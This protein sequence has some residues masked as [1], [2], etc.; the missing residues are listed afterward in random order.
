MRLYH[1]TLVRGC[2]YVEDTETAGAAPLPFLTP[3]PMGQLIP[4]K[5]YPTMLQ[6]KTYVYIISPL[7]PSLLR[8]RYR[9]FRWGLLKRCLYASRERT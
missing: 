2:R 7:S 4:I 8:P 3:V 6:F 9:S 1:L 5:V